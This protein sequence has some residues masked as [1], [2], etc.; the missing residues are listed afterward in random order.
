MP[1]FDEDKLLLYNSKDEEQEE[2]IK[3]WW[4]DTL[5]PLSALRIRCQSMGRGPSNPRRR[6]SNGSSG[7]SE[8]A[9]Q[10]RVQSNSVT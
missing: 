10:V 2:T 6:M 4:E 3:M 5:V 8:K 9:S 1:S 7:S